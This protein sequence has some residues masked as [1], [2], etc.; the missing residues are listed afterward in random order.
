MP[1][2]FKAV[3]VSQRNVKMA[4][5]AGKTPNK[6]ELY[7]VESK[8][9][10]V[11]EMR[12][13]SLKLHTREHSKKGQKEIKQPED[14]ALSKWDLSI[15]GLISFLVESKSMYDTV[16]KILKN[17]DFP[18]SVEL[19]NTGFERSANLQKDLE[20]LKEQGY[21]I[22]EPSSPGADY[23]KYLKKLSEN[24]PQAFICH[25]YNIYFAHT[26]GGQMIGKKVSEKL[27]NSRELNFYKW[28]GDIS[29][30]SQKVK[31]KLNKI[32]EKWTAKE[33]DHCLKETEKTFEYLG[34]ILRL[35]MA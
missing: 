13:A 22:P 32:T 8:S 9:G 6:K 33:K 4:V 27:L 5:I 25:F 26:A 30:L 20:W 17:P 16:E 23:A 18:F 14:R 10:F 11:E 12:A 2:Q 19:E 35:V 31:D 24:D 21:D 29:Q 3:A 1:L 7:S 28:E 15:Q 34:R